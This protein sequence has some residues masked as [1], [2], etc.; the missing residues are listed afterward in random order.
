M[1]QIIV[2][3]VAIAKDCVL[4]VTPVVDLV[5]LVED[6]AEVPACCDPL[7]LVA[8]KRLD[9]GWLRNGLGYILAVA[10]RADRVH[11]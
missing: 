8:I 5:F 2:L 4:S 7:D 11:K 1:R 3:I 6:D 10:S 9:P